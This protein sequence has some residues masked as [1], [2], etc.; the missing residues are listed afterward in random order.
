MFSTIRYFSLVIIIMLA[1]A[2]S[3]KASE[4][5]GRD[6]LG[7]V[8]SNL[9]VEY[10]CKVRVICKEWKRAADSQDEVKKNPFFIRTIQLDQLFPGPDEEVNKAICPSNF[11]SLKLFLRLEYFAKLLRQKGAL[12]DKEGKGFGKLLSVG[13]WTISRKIKDIGHMDSSTIERYN[14]VYSSCIA[15]RACT[16]ATWEDSLYKANAYNVL[17]RNVRGPR[18]REF[19]EN[20]YRLYRYIGEVDKAGD[21]IDF[22]NNEDWLI[23]YANDLIESY[24]A[25]ECNKNAFNKALV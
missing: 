6:V 21:V 13:K 15:D 1:S 14:S 20:A 25:W 10:A 11:L 17:M 3:S 18:I 19:M 12:N 23:E 16:I 4:S 22:C 5:M 9:D 8:L 24:S 7:I 2:A